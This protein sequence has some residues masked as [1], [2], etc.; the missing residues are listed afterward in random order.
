[1]TS[2]YSIEPS[3]WEEESGRVQRPGCGGAVS[4]MLGPRYTRIE[5]A[6]IRLEEIQAI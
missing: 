3:R 4:V 1:M 6:I 5:A 2:K